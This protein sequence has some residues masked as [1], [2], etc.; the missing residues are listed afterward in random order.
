MF[1]RILGILVNAQEESVC[2]NWVCFTLKSLSSATESHVRTFS[3]G[4]F[5]YVKVTIES[6]S[7]LTAE[8]VYLLDKRISI[9]TASFVSLRGHRTVVAELKHFFDWKEMRYFNCLITV[10]ACRSFS[11]LAAQNIRGQRTKLLESCLKHAPE[12]L[13]FLQVH[14][15]SCSQRPLG[16]RIPSEK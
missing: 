7:C 1:S 8:E 10:S 9:E 16:V 4:S 2:L 3:V 12:R 11:S 14:K 6:E 5:R 13:M 15:R